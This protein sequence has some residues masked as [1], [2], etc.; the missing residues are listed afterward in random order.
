MWVGAVLLFAPKKATAQK[1]EAEQDQTIRTLDAL[2]EGAR[3]DSIAWIE[4]NKDV[5][6]GT[7]STEVLFLW[8]PSFSID[9]ARALILSSLADSEPSRRL[10]VRKYVA[11]PTKRLRC[12]SEAE[13]R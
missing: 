11:G 9:S 10:T 1:E 12:A 2:A 6:A 5:I 3:L 13:Q 4:Q 8:V 7:W